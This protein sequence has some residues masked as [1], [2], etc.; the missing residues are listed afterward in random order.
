M[1]KVLKIP[2]FDSDKKVKEI[3]DRNQNC[4]REK[5]LKIWPD[6]VIIKS[7]TKKKLIKWF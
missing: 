6:A 1:L 5:L 4:Y 2:I 3:L 7:N